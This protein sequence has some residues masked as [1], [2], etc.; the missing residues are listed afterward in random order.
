MRTG[1]SASVSELDSQT[2]AGSATASDG[3]RVAYQ[4]W[5][6][7]LGSDNWTAIPGATDTTYTIR[8]ADHGQEVLVEVTA[9]SPDGIIATSTGAR[10]GQGTPGY[11]VRRPSPGF[12][13]SRVTR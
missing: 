10:S 3:A 1:V 9:T 12:S 6:Y 8:P 5:R 11:L 2:L 7:D 4:W 13:P